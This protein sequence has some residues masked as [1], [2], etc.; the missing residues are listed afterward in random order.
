M[1]FL[2]IDKKNYIILIFLNYF[3]L[4]IKYEIFLL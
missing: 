3:E 2:R 1:K 4:L